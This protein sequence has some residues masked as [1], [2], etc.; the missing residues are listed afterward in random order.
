M[1]HTGYSLALPPLI[2][3]G[4]IANDPFCVRM[5]VPAAMPDKLNLR[6]QRG[7]FC[8]GLCTISEVFPSRWRLLLV[9]PSCSCTCL[10]Q[11]TDEDMMWSY[12]L[13]T[14]HL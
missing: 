4:L 6:L 9:S 1:E 13:S 8:T 12:G 10:L 5:Q 3:S 14:E 2:L 7:D 11:T